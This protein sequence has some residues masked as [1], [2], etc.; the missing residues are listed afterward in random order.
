MCGRF[1]LTVSPE[2][3]QAAFPNFH[4]PLDIP[5]SYNI[6][7]SQPI[8]VI[9][10]DGTNNLDFFHWGLIPSWTKVEELGKFN[11]INARSETAGARRRDERGWRAAELRISCRSASL[12]AAYRDEVVASLR[13]EIEVNELLISEFIEHRGKGA[14]AVFL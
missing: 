6:A 13:I 9:P 5:P 3:L 10:N 8:P 2:E 12:A 7:P 1:T 4:I 14:V 11:L